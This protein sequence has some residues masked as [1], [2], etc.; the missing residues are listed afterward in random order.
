VANCVTCGVELHP[1][2]AEK[3]R[4]CTS[5]ECRSKNAKGLTILAVGVNKAS[6]QYVV[7]DERAEQEMASGRYRDPG[8]TSSGRLGGRRPS[9]GG[10]LKRSTEADRETHRSP[11]ISEPEETW[12]QD[13]QDLALAY[14]VTGRLPLEEI[15][16]RLGRDQ[17]TV[18]RMIVAAKARWR[19][20]NTA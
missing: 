19:L 12:T 20:S 15:A 1:E 17:R 3:Y 18:A 13:E 14:E 5:D 4:Y 8:R 10:A 7:L 9:A 2:R 6:D 16:K 11:R